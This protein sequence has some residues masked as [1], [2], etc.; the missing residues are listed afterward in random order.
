[1]ARL[2]RSDLPDGIFHVTSHGIGAASIFREDVDRLDFLSLLAVIAGTSG[3]TMHAHCLL[4]THYHLVVATTAANL[5]TGMQ[6]LNGRYAQLFNHRHRRR[7]HLFEGR[8]RSWVVRDDRHL[9]ATYAYVLQNPVKA[10]LCGAAA[11]WPWSEVVVVREQHRQVLAGAELRDRPRES[12]GRVGD[13]AA[14][15]GAA[16][17]GGVASDERHVSRRVT[18]G[19]DDEQATVSCNVERAREGPDRRPAEV[20]EHGL[21]ERPV[22][23]NIAAQ[24][25]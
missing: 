19:R 2:R 3:W 4:D 20:D 10:R 12:G 7:G 25:P 24:P 18:G 8:F 21:A 22:L 11:D 14:E 15:E 1:M 9:E 6:R 23:G 13:V 5:S 16:G 17:T